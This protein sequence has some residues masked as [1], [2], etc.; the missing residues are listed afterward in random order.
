MAGTKRQA[1]D[2]D[3]ATGSGA[4]RGAD[5]SLERALGQ[6]VRQ[7]RRQNDLSAGDLAAASSLSAGMVSK[8]E[9]GQISPSLSTLNALAG[10]LGV[11]LTALFAAFED[12]S[13]ASH[14]AA[15]AGVVIERRGTKAGHIYRLLGHS[16]RGDVAVEPYLITLEK[17]A[18]PY[19]AF[20]HSGVEFIYMLSGEV[21]YR[22]A[23][24]SYRL[25]PGDSLLFDSGA[26][27]GPEKL[28]RLPSTYLSIIIYPRQA[29]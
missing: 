26:L 5:R 13:D 23:D 9:N 20:R 7:L 29:G 6:Q 21:T 8:I 18:A 22:H 16:L 28:S 25:R 12:R 3:L 4:P 1:L 27:H 24:K 15:G 11:P 10:A 2:S 17:G 14:V 19:T